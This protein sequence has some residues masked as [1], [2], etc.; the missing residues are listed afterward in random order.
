[1]LPVWAHTS[2]ESKM[3]AVI[4]ELRQEMECLS[5]LL[6]V[7]GDFERRQDD[8]ETTSKSGPQSGGE[9]HDNELQTRTYLSPANPLI[10]ICVI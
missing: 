1:M 9:I 10:H 5:A 7:V 6:V 8:H 2:K 4:I 3:I